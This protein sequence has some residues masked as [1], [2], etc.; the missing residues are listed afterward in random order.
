[1]KRIFAAPVYMCEPQAMFR[2]EHS[3]REARPYQDQQIYAMEHKS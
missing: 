3:Y 2:E 1:M